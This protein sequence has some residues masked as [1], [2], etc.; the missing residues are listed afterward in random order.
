VPGR[1]RADAEEAGLIRRRGA[2]PGPPE[3]RHLNAGLPIGFD[4][5][6][7]GFMDAGTF[8]SAEKNAWQHGDPML[9]QSRLRRR[10]IGRW[11]S[12]LMSHDNILSAR[13]VQYGDVP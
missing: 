10:Q 4:A 13:L 11:F 5:V 9:L 6:P 3:T 1:Y 7:D 12:D 2:D 8:L